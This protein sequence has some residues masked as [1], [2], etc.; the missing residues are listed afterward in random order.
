LTLAN[1]GREHETDSL[2]TVLNDIIAHPPDLVVS[3]HTGMQ[4]AGART[5]DPAEVQAD[6]DRLGQTVAVIKKYSNKY[7]THLDRKPKAP[8]PREEEIEAAID[9]IGELL[10]KYMLLISGTDL[11]LETRI[12]FDW[13]GSLTVPWLPLQSS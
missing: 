5:I 8:V 3:E 6:V 1:G 11:D 4:L 10:K 9:L 2:V 13:T 12:L 7:V